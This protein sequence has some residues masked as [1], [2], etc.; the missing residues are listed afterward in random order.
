M[1]VVRARP[2]MWPTACWLVVKIS[3]CSRRDWGW[4]WA[5]CCG[6]THPW[7][8]EE[9]EASVAEEVHC[10]VLAYLKPVF[11]VDLTDVSAPIFWRC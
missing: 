7:D 6:A 10:G 11:E 8:I 5:G 2:A 3:D 4:I 9:V 1:G